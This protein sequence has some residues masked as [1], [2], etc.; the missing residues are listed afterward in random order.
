[1]QVVQ[2]VA[3][4]G[5]DDELALPA[6]GVAHLGIVLENAREF[7]PLAVLA[8]SDDGL[9]L[10]FEPLED[11]DFGLQL[12]DGAGRRGLIDEVL[13]EVLLLLGVEVV[14]VLGHV[15]ERFGEDLLAAD[16]ELL[17]PQAA[18]EPL[19]A[20]LERLVDGLGA[21][22]EAALE[23]GEREADRAFARAVELVGL[24]HFRLDVLGDGL[25][26]GGLD[27]GELVVD[28]VGP[29]LGEERG[30]VELDHLLLHHAAH[31]VGAI[32][33]VDAVAEL[34]VEAVGVEQRQEELEVLLLAVVRRGGH[35][36]QVPR[37]LRRASR[38]S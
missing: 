24:A 29:A 20:A 3:V 21:G 25:V 36:Q 37:M 31:E 2:C 22:G 19:L 9:G 28:R 8:R 23:G 13:F 7:V 33:L 12:G 18:F 38:R 15:G 4:L 30:A 5:E 35:Q 26:E 17:L 6:A 27:V 11:D 1:M 14:V 16:A 10:L 32:D 34:A